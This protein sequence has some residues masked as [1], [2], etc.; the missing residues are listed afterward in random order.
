MTITVAP[1]PVPLTPD[2]H[3][4][5]RVGQTRVTLDILVNAFRSGQSPEEIREQ[6]PAVDLADIYAVLA[7][8]LR[9][10]AEVDSYMAQQARESEQARDEMEAKFPPHGLRARLLARRST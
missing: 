5:M 4:I 2:A 3:G 7:Y 9:H 6:Y 8:Y 10:T 1:E